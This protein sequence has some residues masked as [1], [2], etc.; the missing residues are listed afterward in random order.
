M[1]VIADA[2][3]IHPSYL[4]KVTNGAATITMD[5]KNTPQYDTYQK[6]KDVL[7]T[8]NPDNLFVFTIHPLIIKR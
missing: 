5:L 6:A 4:F 3:H 2:R 7:V 8:I 1:F